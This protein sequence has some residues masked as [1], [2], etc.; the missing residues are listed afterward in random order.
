M[1][2]LTGT[3]PGPYRTVAVKILPARWQLIQTSGTG[4]DR[5][6][7]MISQLTPRQGRR[8]RSHE[9][10][11]RCLGTILTIEGGTAISPDGSAVAFAARA[12]EEGASQKKRCVNRAFGGSKAHEPAVD[13]QSVIERRCT[14]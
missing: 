1:S 6:A 13:E 11:Y 7:R 14:V 4:F 2:D 9:R 5:E 12:A 10:R 3:R 8:H